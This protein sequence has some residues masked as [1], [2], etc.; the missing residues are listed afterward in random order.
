MGTT[1]AAAFFMLS[2]M[3]SYYVAE[4]VRIVAIQFTPRVLEC[5]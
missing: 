3:N 2:R 4:G 5:G 1:R